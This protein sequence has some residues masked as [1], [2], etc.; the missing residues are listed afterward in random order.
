MKHLIVPVIAL[1]VCSFAVPKQRTFIEDWTA[2]KEAM[3]NYELVRKNGGDTVSAGAVIVARA[4]DV[5]SHGD[6]EKNVKTAYGD[7]LTCMDIC[8]IV[9]VGCTVALNNHKPCVD[10]YFGCRKF[11]LGY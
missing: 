2:Y 10:L 8:Y 11:C 4:I 9:G 3:D 5:Q 6:V 1:I 7:P